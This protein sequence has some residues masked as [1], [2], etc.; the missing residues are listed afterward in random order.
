MAQLMTYLP[1]LTTYL[2]ALMNWLWKSKCCDSSSGLAAEYSIPH[3]LQATAPKC[4]CP[5]FCGTTKTEMHARIPA[6]GLDS[7]HFPLTYINS[8]AV[9]FVGLLRFLHFSLQSLYVLLLRRTTAKIKIMNAYHSCLEKNS[10]T[11]S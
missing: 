3:T 10:G 1:P 2:T 4:F 6:H 5:A 7:S 9:V 11:Y 8:L